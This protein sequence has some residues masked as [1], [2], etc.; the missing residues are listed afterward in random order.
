MLA[1]RRFRLAF[2]I[3]SSSFSAHW[4]GT[5]PGSGT[6][7][8]STRGRCDY[9]F[10][11]RRLSS[12]FRTFSIC[13]SSFHTPTTRSPASLSGSLTATTLNSTALSSM[14]SFA[15]PLVVTIAVK[16]AS[17]PPLVRNSFLNLEKSTV[18]SLLILGFAYSALGLQATA[19]TLETLT[20]LPSEAR[21][22]SLSR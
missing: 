15:L 17:D 2:G 5:D 1:F 4:T 16:P 11:I 19:S 14:R 6:V 10:L 18:E 21:A 8:H 13:A 9:L 20:L 7:P 22:R 12:V 3:S